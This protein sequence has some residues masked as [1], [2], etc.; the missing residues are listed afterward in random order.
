ML[1]ILIAI[2]Q[3]IPEQ[4]MPGDLCNWLLVKTLFFNQTFV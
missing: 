2:N 4:M 3:I 1:I